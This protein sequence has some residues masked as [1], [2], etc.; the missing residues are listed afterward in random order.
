M[1]HSLLIFEGLIAE[2]ALEFEVLHECFN[3]FRE[4]FLEITLSSALR[5]GIFKSR[6]MNFT[7]ASLAA[8]A[9][10]WIKSYLVQANRANNQIYVFDISAKF[11]GLYWN[12]H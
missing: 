5:T 10:K 2:A 6:Q 7:K 12:F 1:F 4:P 3:L 9:F 11:T 8:F